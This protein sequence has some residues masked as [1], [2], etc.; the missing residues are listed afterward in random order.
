MIWN[1]ALLIFVFTAEK[2]KKS[3]YLAAGIF[4]VVKFA[5]YA[6]FSRNLVVAVLMGALFAGLTAGFVYFLRRLDRREDAERDDT[7]SYRSPGAEK[8]KFR[9][10]Y[11]PLVVLLMLIIGGE[12]LLR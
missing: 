7:P 1:I 6:M 11:F 8:M 5:L 2:K 10:E 9:W 4:G 12:I 3:P